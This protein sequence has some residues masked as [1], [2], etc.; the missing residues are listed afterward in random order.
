[1][2]RRQAIA[3][4]ATLGVLPSLASAREAPTLSLIGAAWRGPK[5]DDPYF[6]GV[7]ASDWAAAKLSIRYAVPLPTRPHGILAEA[8]G[9][10]LV[11]GVR[12]GA[13]LLRC[14]GEGRIIRRENLDDASSRLGGHGIMIGDHLYTTETDIRSGR[15]RIGVRDRHTLVKL[16]EW[17]CHGIDPHQLVADG[18]GRLL[19]ANGGV[20]R[21]IPGDRKHGLERMASSLVRL[22]GSNGRLIAQWRLEDPRL[23]L[24]HLAW[25]HDPARGDAWLGVALQAEHDDPTARA[26]APLLAVLYDD[27]LSLP[28]GAGEGNGYAGDIAA[29]ADGGF[30]VSSNQAGLAQLWHPGA[31]ERL[32]PVIRLKETYAL[33]SLPDESGHTGLLVS[34]GLGLVRWL[35]AGPASFLPWP[36]PMA[37]DNHWTLAA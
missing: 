23:S 5:P 35:P 21:T 14:D 24:R 13:W 10:L 2:N 16:D 29:A 20:P 31:P 33:A 18:Q 32:T 8:G 15:G 9:G 26:A 36:E 17:D 6:A 28:A 3:T 7:L 4:L 12:P 30:V 11:I 34:T 27:A 1:M 19:V 25:S 37:V 22:D